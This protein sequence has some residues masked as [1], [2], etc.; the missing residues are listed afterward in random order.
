MSSQYAVNS[1]LNL[2]QQFLARID[3]GWV[4][5]AV[6]QGVH[7]T[8]QFFLRRIRTAY[9]RV[10]T[11]ALLFRIVIVVPFTIISVI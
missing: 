5:V 11:V 7:E 8:R 2:G 9:D 10:P 4:E 6:R 3:Q 1:P